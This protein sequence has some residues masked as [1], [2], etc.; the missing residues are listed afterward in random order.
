MK[1]GNNSLVTMKAAAL[2]CITRF[3]LLSKLYQQRD[4][5]KNDSLRYAYMYT[6]SYLDCTV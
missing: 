1:K 3:V 5:L 6:L 4:D 2:L